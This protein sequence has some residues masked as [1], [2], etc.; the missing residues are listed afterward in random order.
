MGQA[1]RV[2]LR[3]GYESRLVLALVCLVLLGAALLGLAESGSSQDARTSAIVF[4]I[5]AVAACVWFLVAIA[6]S[7]VAVDEN[8]IVVRP[9]AGR[10]LQPRACFR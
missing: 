3:G 4:L 9:F 1:T 7:A 6:R 10:T 2:V 8:E 5:P